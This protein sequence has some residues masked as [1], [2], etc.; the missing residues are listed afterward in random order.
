[1][2]DVE[3]VLERDLEFSPAIVWDALVDPVLVGG[4]LGDAQIDRTLGG[5]FDI[6]WLDEQD[7]AASHGVIVELD[8]PNAVA[9][10]TDDGGEV[11][12]VLSEFAGG[13][14]GS[15]TALR[16]TVTL[17]IEPVFA[18]GVRAAWEARLDRLDDLL[19][20]RPTSRAV[21]RAHDEPGERLLI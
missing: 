10:S 9:I 12:F 13:S 3:L 8:Q 6:S 17:A 1:V 21:L 4:W 18:S 2:V 15:S 20:G 19:H 11:R 16:L 14:R 5:R 7:R